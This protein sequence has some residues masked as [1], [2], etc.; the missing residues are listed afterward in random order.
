VKGFLLH[1]G[2]IVEKRNN[3]CKNPYFF[4][5]NKYANSG[6]TSNIVHK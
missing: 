6:Q 5:T 2:G 3:C 1:I 4:V